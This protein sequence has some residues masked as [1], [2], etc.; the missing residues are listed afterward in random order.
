MFRLRFPLQP[1]PEE[2]VL[3]PRPEPPKLGAIQTTSPLMG[4]YRVATIWFTIMERS[5]AEAIEKLKATIKNDLHDDPSQVDMIPCI[6]DV[7]EGK[8]MREQGSI[9]RVHRRMATIIA[10]LVDRLVRY[11]PESRK[12]AWDWL[13]QELVNWRPLYKDYVCERF[14]APVAEESEKPK[15]RGG[16]GGGIGDWGKRFPYWCAKCG[17]G[18]GSPEQVRKHFERTGHGDE[19]TQIAAKGLTD[20]QKD[21]AW[22]E[23]NK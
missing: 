11:N 19:A 16:G 6:V 2:P 15:R 20:K 21:L 8:T 9:N 5:Y 23:M 3:V 10:G 14:R 12:Y 1:S 17:Y 22:R 18:F 4:D 7:K 13:K